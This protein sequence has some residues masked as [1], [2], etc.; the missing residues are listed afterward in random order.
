MD[1]PGYFGNISWIK[2]SITGG[3]FFFFLRNTSHEL[4]GCFTEGKVLAKI[5]NADFYLQVDSFEYLLILI[6]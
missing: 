4:L 1:I 6:K 2:R 3:S 5:G